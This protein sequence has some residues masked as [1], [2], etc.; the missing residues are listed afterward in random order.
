[1]DNLR[2]DFKSRFGPWALIAGASKGLGAEYARQ[3]A[4]KGINLAL[5]ARRRDRLEGLAIEIKERFSVQIRIIEMDLGRQD[6][7]EQIAGQVGDLDI[8]L[9]ICNAA[10]TPVA[11]FFEITLEQHL[12]A[13]DTNVR[14]PLALVYHFG[15]LM[16]DRRR[17]GIILMSSLSAYQG[18]ALI[19]NYAAT[20]AYMLT[21]AE[22]LWDEL[23]ADGIAVVAS[24]PASIANVTE[25]SASH[26]AKQN[27][28]QS[29]LPEQVAAETL[30]G[31][32]KQPSVI[33]GWTNRLA[34]FAIRKLI[35]RPSMIRMMGNV[36][37]GIYE[38][39]S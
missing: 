19:S 12:N 36:M 26:S 25:Q 11:P 30:A 16:R 1:M 38:K 32:G 13:I 22:G 5:V 37:R 14:T 35:P 17:G 20:K 8:G 23:R 18:S 15:R 28:S 31:L 3:L 21:L 27:S 9:L 2:I 7:A 33:P 34:G 29:L 4:A 24:L 39:A 10:V 6:A